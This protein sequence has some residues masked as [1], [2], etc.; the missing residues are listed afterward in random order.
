MKDKKPKEQHK[1]PSSKVQRASR[2]ARA[3]AKVGRNYVSHY[4]RKLFNKNLDRSDL[5]ARNAEDIYNELSQLKGGALKVAQMLSMDKGMLPREYTRKFANAQYKAPPLSGPLIVKTFR[6]HFGKGPSEIFDEFDMQAS[7]AASIGQVHRAVLNGKKLAVKV[8][9][10]GIANSIRSDLRLVRPFASRFMK[11]PDKDL[12][13]FFEEVEERLLEECDYDLELRN[14]MELSAACAHIPNLRFPEYFP[15]LSSDRVIT[16]EWLDGVHMQEFMATDPPAEV[17]NQ[18][19]Q[20]MFDFIT[21]QSHKLQKMHADPHPGNFLMTPD[22]KLGVLDFGCVKV[23]PQ[24]FYEAFFSVL[25]P[26]V[27]KDPNRL[28]EVTYKLEL[29]NREDT[30]EDRTFVLTTLNTFFDLVMKPFEV[31]R[32][33]FGDDSYLD[34]LY[35]FGLEVGQMSDVQQKHGG[36]GS[37]HAIYINRTFFGMFSL[38]NDLKA[39]IDARDMYIAPAVLATS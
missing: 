14:S 6:Q 26:A 21:F 36:R 8:Q 17:R 35:K 4:T 34:E 37:K 13:P 18:I 9:Y 27:R 12:A 29:L 23:I 1:L 38:L 33:D 32:F 15:E 11:V 31:E 2:F 7:Y 24:D 10:P 39:T 3:G 22:G 28:L 5:D 19:G 30:E 20:A 25:D 16:M